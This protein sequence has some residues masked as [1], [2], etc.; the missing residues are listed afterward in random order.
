MKIPTKW[1]FFTVSTRRHLEMGRIPVS[2]SRLE[3]AYLECVAADETVEAGFPVLRVGRLKTGHG[4]T[5][6]RRV[7]RAGFGELFC[8]VKGPV[9][10]KATM[11]LSLNPAQCAARSRL[12]VIHG[13]RSNLGF[14]KCV[15]FRCGGPHAPQDQANKNLHHTS[16]SMVLA[17]PKVFGC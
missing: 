3:S 6:V 1:M 9:C 8:R 14:E 7:G 15:V 13:Q 5:F 10:R 17:S 12:A 4:Q 2:P 16:S 11:R